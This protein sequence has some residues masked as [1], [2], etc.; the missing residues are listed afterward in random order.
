MNIRKTN[1][2][3]QDSPTAQIVAIYLL[4][5]ETPTNEQII[6]NKKYVRKCT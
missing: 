6:V 5:N 3:D 1:M 2:Q 4:T